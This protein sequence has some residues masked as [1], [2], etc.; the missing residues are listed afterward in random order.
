MGCYAGKVI[1]YDKDVLEELL[2]TGIHACNKNEDCTK[3]TV[4]DKKIRSGGAVFLSNMKWIGG[5]GSGLIPYG[6]N[7]KNVEGSYRSFADSEID[8]VNKIRIYA[9]G[10]IVVFS[11]V[12]FIFCSVISSIISS[13]IS[14]MIF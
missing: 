3:K 6:E 10:T 11:V 4:L 8:K 7:A 9:G 2:N 12:L 5:S 13:S 14:V 1:A